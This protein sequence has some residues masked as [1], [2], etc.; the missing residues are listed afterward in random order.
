MDISNLRY[1]F[2]YLATLALS[3]K[4]RFTLPSLDNFAVVFPLNFSK[5]RV[6]KILHFDNL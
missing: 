1:F 3:N 6:E 4:V 5:T 2:F